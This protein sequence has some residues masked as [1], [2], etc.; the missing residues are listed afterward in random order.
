[1]LCK[2]LVD[3]LVL[4]MI[5]MIHPL[6]IKKDSFVSVGGFTFREIGSEFGDKGSKI[7][8]MWHSTIGSTGFPFKSKKN[9][10]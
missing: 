6:Y 2:S 9:P 4:N 3:S 7:S 8:E 10:K 5:D 1:M